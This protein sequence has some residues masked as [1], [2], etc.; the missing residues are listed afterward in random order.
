MGA[1]AMDVAD[2]HGK[3]G[4]KYDGAI[5]QMMTYTDCLKKNGIVQ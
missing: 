1:V 2:I 4:S 5:A 3:F